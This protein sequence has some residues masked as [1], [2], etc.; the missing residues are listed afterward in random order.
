MVSQPALFWLGG[1]AVHETEKVL[2]Q[3]LNC[4]I[5]LS[6]FS[7]C[8]SCYRG[9]K[10]CSAPC[11]MQA[12]RAQRRKAS[13]RYQSS[14]SG[15]RKHRLRQNSY[16]RRQQKNVTHGSSPP[17]DNRIEPPIGVV[18]SGS[19]RLLAA[20]SCIVCRQGIDFFSNEFTTSP[21]TDRQRK[22]KKGKYDQHRRG[23]RGPPSV[24]R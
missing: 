8:H 11:Q 22:K 4:P 18:A 17:S 23:G 5:C 16:R 3:I 20:V 12:L 15:K 7:V 1:C 21:V 10:Y 6:N 24:L 19:D 9:Q 13:V 2:G 14:A